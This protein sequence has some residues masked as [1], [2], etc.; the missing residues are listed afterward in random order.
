MAPHIASIG[1]P[2]D[3]IIWAVPS[4]SLSFIAIAGNKTIAVTAPIAPPLDTPIKAGSASGFRKRPCS[5]EPAS[6]NAAPTKKASTIL[7]SLISLITIDLSCDLEEGSSKEKV[8][9]TS[10]RVVS[11]APLFR[12][13]NTQINSSIDKKQSTLPFESRPFFAAFCCVAR[14]GVGMRLFQ[15]TV[16]LGRRGLQ[17]GYSNVE[18]LLLVVDRKPDHRAAQDKLRLF[19]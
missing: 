1:S 11:T 10:L 8:A 19:L 13:Q 9:I 4:L 16:Y 5:S 3:C 17:E 14:L 2:K 7:G 15:I 12:D 6:V 18:Q